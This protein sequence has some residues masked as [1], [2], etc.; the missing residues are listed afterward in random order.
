[1]TS[2]TSFEDLTKL[3]SKI[4]LSEV[5]CV[6][7]HSDLL[8]F[9]PYLPFKENILEDLVTLLEDQIIFIP[10]FTIKSFIRNGIYDICDS[11]PETGALPRLAHRSNWIRTT[12]PMHSYFASR[13]DPLFDDFF[14]YPTDNY[15]TY[16]FGHESILQTLKYIANN[17]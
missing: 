13:H 16:S 2:F 10:S 15:K 3:V 6:I 9:G 5:R 1:M 17:T 8:A 14:K 7:I 12:N 4:N 11:Q